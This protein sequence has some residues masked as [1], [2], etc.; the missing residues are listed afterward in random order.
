MKIPFDFLPPI[1]CNEKSLNRLSSNNSMFLATRA[2]FP[3]AHLCQCRRLH[4]EIELNVTFVAPLSV[5]LF[6]YFASLYLLMMMSSDGV[7][8]YFICFWI[9]F[10]FLLCELIIGFKWISSVTG[11]FLMALITK[12][13]IKIFRNKLS[14]IR[15]QIL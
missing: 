12:E 7:D 2:Q 13:T 6:V 10:I 5:H 15:G 11:R 1:K 14:H 9:C 8:I 3:V 4:M